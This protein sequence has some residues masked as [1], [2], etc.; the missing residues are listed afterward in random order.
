LFKMYDGKVI[1][2]E[3]RAYQ[4]LDLNLGASRDMVKQVFTNSLIYVEKLD[5]NVKIFIN[6]RDAPEINLTE[7]QLIIT[8]FDRFYVTNSAQAGKSCNLLIAN[9]DF[10]R[11]NVKGSKSHLNLKDVLPDQH[12]DTK[13]RSKVVD[14]GAIADGKILEYD[15]AAG[16][17][18]YVAPSG[19]AAIVP[20]TLVVAANDSKDKTR[21]DY[22]CD[23]VSDQVEINNA[24]TTLPASGGEVSLLE[25]TFIVDGIT[26]SI[27]ISKDNVTLVGTGAGT[28]IKI[29]DNFNN[30]LKVIY[31]SSKSKLILSKFRID[32]NKANQS[33]GGYVGIFLTSVINSEVNCWVEDLYTGS[34]AIYL[35]GSDKNIVR[36]CQCY[37]NYQGIFLYGSVG[38]LIIGNNA[39][40]NDYIGI[41]IDAVSK[42]NIIAQNLC[43]GNGHHGINLLLGTDGNIVSNN[44][45]ELSGRDGIAIDESAQNNVLDRNTLYHNCQ[46]VVNTY[47]EIKLHG[48]LPPYVHHNLILNNTILADDAEYG[49]NEADANQDYNIIVGNIVSG[50]MT[51]NIRIQGTHTII[52]INI[53]RGSSTIDNIIE[54][55]AGEALSTHDCV[56]ISANNTVMKTTGSTSKILGMVYEDVLINE[57]A[58]VI[59]A[60]PSK[61]NVSGAVVAGDLLIGAAAGKVI[62]FTPTTS[63]SSGSHYHMISRNTNTLMTETDLAAGTMSGIVSGEF[64]GGKIIGKA[65]EGGTDTLIKIVVW[66]GG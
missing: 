19:G 17:L 66:T 51:K 38:N 8:P 15:A 35:W 44:I 16:T 7:S 63:K 36:N 14:E 29:K 24:I 48:T 41:Y 25:G 34:P 9:A 18:K 30:N 46:S 11:V 33:S 23:G 12:A 57:A 64:S 10:F 50:A 62:K 32:G 22:Q 13:V 27:I 4:R 52:G 20:V 47:S 61:A 3:Y 45:V 21:A 1:P 43:S 40:N 26:N 28:T 55:T 2:K 42:N 49:I 5:G 59:V 60:G 6:H 53:P 37:G 65:L 39:S 58:Y 31:A 54:M 56:Y